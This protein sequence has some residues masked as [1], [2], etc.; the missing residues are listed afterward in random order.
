[1]TAQLPIISTSYDMDTGQWEILAT[2]YSRTAPAGPRLFR[3]PPFLDIEFTHD[4]E[5]GANRDAAKLREYLAGVAAKRGP[6]KAK[7]R[8]SG[9]D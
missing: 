6:S 5:D 7:L 2:S 8:K 1:M 9:A 3:A 4:T